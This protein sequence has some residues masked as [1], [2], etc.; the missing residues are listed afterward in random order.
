MECLRPLS[1]GESSNRITGLVR[2]PERFLGPTTS[3]FSS[4]RAATRVLMYSSSLFRFRKGPV[5]LVGSSMGLT[6]KGH[7]APFVVELKRLQM[8]KHIWLFAWHLLIADKYKEL[9]DHVHVALSTIVLDEMVEPIVFAF[10]R[11]AEW[12]AAIRLRYLMLWKS[13]PSLCNSKRKQGSKI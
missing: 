11:A 6:V 4:T 8:R 7:M 5:S 12:E 10:E 9:W 2:W 1:K 13:K 3:S